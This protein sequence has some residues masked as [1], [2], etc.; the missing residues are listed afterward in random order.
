MKPPLSDDPLK[1]RIAEY[2]S[3][4]SPAMLRVATFIDA[5]RV[6]AL[7][8]SAAELAARA[9]TSD[10]TVVRTAKALGFP[11]LAGLRQM[12]AGAMAARP[13]PTANMVHTLAETGS[14]I[15]EAIDLVLAAHD[16]GLASLRQPDA[17]AQIRAAVA[18]LEPVARIALFGIGQTAPLVS[19][20]AIMMGRSGRAVLRCDAT[21]IAFADQLL[22]LN[23]G[24]GALIIAYGDGY[25]EVE[26]IVQKA[27]ALRL[28]MVLLTDSLEERLAARADIVIPVARGRTQRVALHAV[29]LAAL[30]AIAVGLAAAAPGRTMHALDELDTLRSRLRRKK[31]AAKRH[32]ETPHKGQP[33]R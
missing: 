1:L 23:T 16:E 32:R 12:I 17:R 24:D 8:S 6:T 22:G 9:S 11:G 26:T 4:L 31:P 18:L 7:T 5:N 21:G 14:D 33:P 10:V 30:E 29:T 13:S 20:L 15:D 25:P 28:P 3:K 19:Y 2:R 27:T